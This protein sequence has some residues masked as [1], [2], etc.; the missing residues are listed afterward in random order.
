MGALALRTIVHT[1]WDEAQLQRPASE[2]SAVIPHGEYGGLA[3]TGGSA[4][5]A[6]ARAELGI[7]GDAPVTLM[8][9]QL[10]HDK[11]IG[12]LLEAVRRVPD[13][14]LVMGGQDTGGLGE[15]AEQ[16]AAPELAGRVVIREGFLSM[17]EAAKL[18]AATDTVA[19]PYQ[20]ASQSGVLLLSYGFARPVVVY[21]VGGLPEAVVEGET[22]WI[23]DRR[24]PAALA[25]AL[26]QSVEAGWPECERRGQAGAQLADERYSWAEIARMTENVYHA[27]LGIR[28]PVMPPAA[29]VT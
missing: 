13:L 5:R 1:R 3:R 12:D 27:A 26:R 7:P 9:G 11:G 23:S 28:Q 15:V 20:V 25:D 22:G 24:D 6:Q 8:F 16:L 2:R 14:Y 17:A 4:D 21:P 29:E 19:L 18:F 10:R